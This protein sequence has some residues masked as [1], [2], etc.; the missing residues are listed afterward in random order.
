MAGEAPGGTSQAWRRPRSLPIAQEI[1]HP[2]LIDPVEFVPEKQR[3][4]SVPK[5]YHDP[6]SRDHDSTAAR[7]MPVGV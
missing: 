2:V 3:E 7:A 6:V 5:G 1:Q 4:S